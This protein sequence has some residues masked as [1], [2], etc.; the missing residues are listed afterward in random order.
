MLESSG[1]SEGRGSLL[2]PRFGVVGEEQLEAMARGEKRLFHGSAVR[3][4][5]KVGVESRPSLVGKGVGSSKGVLIESR[6][7]GDLRA[8]RQP[9]MSWNSRNFGV[10]GNSL[11]VVRQSWLGEKTVPSLMAGDELK[12]CQDLQNGDVRVLPNVL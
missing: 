10:L 3:G 8:A 7:R 6:S 12:P 11:G 5:P 1:R 2:L 4:V 9:A